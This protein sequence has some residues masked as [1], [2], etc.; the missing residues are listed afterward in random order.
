MIAPTADNIVEAALGVNH[1][2]PEFRQAQLDELRAAMPGVTPDMEVGY[3][4]GVQAG[5]CVIA[6]GGKL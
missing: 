2:S 4:L 6:Q 5:R 1:L 3:L